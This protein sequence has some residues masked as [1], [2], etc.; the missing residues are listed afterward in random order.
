[1]DIITEMESYARAHDVPI[2]EKEGIA[3]MLDVIQTHGCRRILEIGTAIGYSAIRM[4]LVHEDIHVVS[5]ERDEQRWQEACRN[6]EKAGLSSRI[7]LIRWKRRSTENLIFCSSMR[8]RR[9]TRASLSATPRCSSKAGSCFQTILAFTAW[10]KERRCR[11]AAERGI[12]CARSED[13]S[14]I[15]NTMQHLKRNSM[16]WATE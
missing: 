10:W 1:M 14:T 16:M 13:T 12:W 11:R 4:A 3:F 7:T 6:V 8:P 15:W 2:M 5:I 9:N